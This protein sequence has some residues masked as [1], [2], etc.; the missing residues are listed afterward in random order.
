M[1]NQSFFTWKYKRGIGIYCINISNFKPFPRL[2]T[3]FIWRPLTKYLNN[4]VLVNSYSISLNPCSFVRLHGRLPTIKWS[5][6]I[7]KGEG[8][9]VIIL[10]SSKCKCKLC[11]HIHWFYRMVRRRGRGR[12]QS[13]NKNIQTF[14]L[15]FPRPP[16]IIL[17]SRTVHSYPS[18]LTIKKR[19]FLEE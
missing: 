8:G 6:N 7:P 5:T 9:G 12:G 19:Y 18:V 17:S 16:P 2:T 4:L 10:L 15:F 1:T 11:L 14:F 3:T 13:Q